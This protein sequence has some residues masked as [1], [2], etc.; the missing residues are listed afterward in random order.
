MPEPVRVGGRPSVI[1]EPPDDLDETAKEFWADVVPVLHQVG[2]LDTVD[3]AALEMLC[4]QYARAKQAA[5]IVAENGH[6]TEGSTGQLVE[7]PALATERNAMAAFM[8]FAEQYAL[9]PVAR[10]RLGLAELQRR[11]L[12]EEMKESLGPVELEPA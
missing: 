2:I 6:L 3:R 1:L 11:S 5:R 9:T 7:H 8:K 12:Q 10:T 4:T